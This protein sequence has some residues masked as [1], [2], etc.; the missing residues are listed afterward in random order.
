MAEVKE[1]QGLPVRERL[2]L[3][4]SDASTCYFVCAGFM[5]LCGKK[6]IDLS[7]DMI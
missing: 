1:Q 3:G 4:Y 6:N 5:K 7:Y 2:Q